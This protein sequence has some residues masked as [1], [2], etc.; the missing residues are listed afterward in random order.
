[1]SLFVL[2]FVYDNEQEYERYR[3]DYARWLGADSTAALERARHLGLAGPA[4]QVTETL[5]RYVAHGFD[6]VIALF[7]YTREREL[8]Q[9]YAEEVWPHI[10]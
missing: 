2:T 3:A 4:A 10:M 5:R 8:L 6:Y 1:M 9:R 7:P